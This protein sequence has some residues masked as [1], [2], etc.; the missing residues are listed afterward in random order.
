MKRYRE[1]LDEQRA[2]FVKG[3]GMDKGNMILGASLGGNPMLPLPAPVVNV[4]NASQSV[5]ADI[6]SS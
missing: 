2:K 3:Q 4:A 5:I 6:S 1:M